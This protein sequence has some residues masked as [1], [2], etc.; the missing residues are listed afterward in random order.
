MCKESQNVGLHPG[1]Y[2]KSGLETGVFLW[3]MRIYS[4]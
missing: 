1:L 2:Y 4:K 3:I